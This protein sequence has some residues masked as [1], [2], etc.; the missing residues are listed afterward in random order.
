MRVY[1][2][3]AMKKA[4]GALNKT[5]T[6]CND[7]Y[8]ASKGSDCLLVLTDWDEFKELDFLKI[9]KLL[10]RPVILDGRNIYDPQEMRKLGFTYE[11]IG[12]R[13]KD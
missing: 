9:K 7:A 4:A 10:K 1:D 13:S 2:P 6:F 5:V 8:S 3:K 11:S 12:R